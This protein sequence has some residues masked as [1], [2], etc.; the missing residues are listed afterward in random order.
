MHCLKLVLPCVVAFTG[1][2]PILA[3]VD[4][5]TPAEPSEVQRAV[6]RGL[7]Y[8]ERQSMVWWNDHKC[9]A[10]HEGSMLLFSHNVAKRQGVPIDQE[11]LD[12]WTDRWW[13][14]GA[15]SKVREKNKKD[16]G[17]A[18]SIAFN[19]LYRD[20]DRERSPGDIPAIEEILSTMLEGQL[21]GGNWTNDPRLRLDPWIILAL[22]SAEKSKL[23]IDPALRRDVT[24]TRQRSEEWFV[25][26]RPALPE[27]NEE[28]AAWVVYDHERGE[29]AQEKLVL[30]ELLSRQRPDGGWGMTKDSEN[31]LLVTGAA[32]FALKSVGLSNEHRAVA[33]AQRFLLDRQ[34]ADGRWREKGRFFHLDK[35]YDS[36]DAWT[37][38]IVAAALSLTLNLP[39]GAPRQFTPDAT[40]LEQVARLTATAAEDYTGEYLEGDPTVKANA[41]K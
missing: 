12:F 16:V 7:F 24:T 31:H 15:Q 13:F 32:L 4:P 14:T 41:G 23:A 34:Q 26:N 25:N 21:P 19:L 17:G 6:E 3:Q 27:K 36:T 5:G 11:K 40:L 10:C 39:P 18:L 1:I 35:Y 38:G 28:L 30:D 8:V 20:L 22:A 2:D 9:F 29:Q 37:S 33:Q